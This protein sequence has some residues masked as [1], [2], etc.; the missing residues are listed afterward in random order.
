MLSL[1]E[2]LCLPLVTYTFEALN[3]SEQQLTRLNMCWNREYREAF[4]MNDTE[5]AKEYCERY[6]VGW[7]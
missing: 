4:C 3:Y 6:V 1:T 2:T 7:I 5:S